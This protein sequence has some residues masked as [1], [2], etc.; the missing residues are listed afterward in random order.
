LVVVT[1]EV[2]AG[3][4]HQIH[5]GRCLRVR[6]CPERTAGIGGCSLHRH[7]RFDFHAVIG[8][9]FQVVYGDFDGIVVVSSGGMPIR[10]ESLGMVVKEGNPYK[11][12]GTGNG[13]I[14]VAYRLVFIKIDGM[15]E[16]LF[17][18]AVTDGN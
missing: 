15:P 11:S 13:P 10:T 6:G 17:P 14:H 3:T 9:A 16:Y 1:P 18:P 5:G 2:L 4:G 8:A 12:R 7:A